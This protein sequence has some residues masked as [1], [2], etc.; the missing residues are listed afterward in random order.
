MT[1]Y[2]FESF[3]DTA[4]FLVENHDTL[5]RYIK[6]NYCRVP[7]EHDPGSPVSR[8]KHQAKTRPPTD[9]ERKLL[10]REFSPSDAPFMA[11]NNLKARCRFARIW[12]KRCARFGKRRRA[13][14]V[15]FALDRFA[16]TLERAKLFSLRKLKSW[17]GEALRGFDYIAN[18]EVAPYTN[19]QHYFLRGNIYHLHVHA[20]VFDGDEEELDRRIKAVTMKHPSLLPGCPSGHYEQIKP[21][22]LEHVLLYIMKAPTFKYRA[23]ARR[24]KVLDK[25]TNS[26]IKV[27]AGRYGQLSDHANPGLQLLVRS[28]MVGWHL[29]RVIFAGGNARELLKEIRHEALSG[30]L[31]RMHSKRQSLFSGAFKAVR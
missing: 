21:D 10:L 12:M 11:A 2:R 29:D 18:V 17:V 14:L 3:K 4:A 26:M 30:L 6:S 31:R 23:Y 9:L 16:M 27:H 20:I 22:T 24:T 1:E 15:T 25:R 5:R 19:W 8:I 13:Y 28:I 7:I